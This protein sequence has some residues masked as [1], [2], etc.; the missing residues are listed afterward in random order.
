MA[1]SVS[2]T[3]Q[4]QI[5]NRAALESIGF[6]QFKAVN[7]CVTPAIAEQVTDINLR[8]ESI[9]D[10]CI[11]FLSKFWNLKTINLLDTGITPQGLETLRRVFPR[12]VIRHESV[13]TS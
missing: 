5:V 10:R 2:A 8:M 11:P 3:L 13:P 7:S 1:H 12:L 9:D 4:E 6:D